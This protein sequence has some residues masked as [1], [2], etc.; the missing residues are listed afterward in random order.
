M[1]SI[2]IIEDEPAV[3]KEISY[4]I[5]QEEGAEIV[6]WSDSVK[7]ALI[8]IKEKQ[9]DVILMDIQLRDGTAFDI[10]K[11]LTPIPE[12]IIF[13]TAYNQFAIRAIKYGA[14]DY[15][16]K[17]IDQGELKEALER[18]RRR[19]SNNSQW[20]QQLSL[21]QEALKEEVILP[22]S[23]ALHSL[24]HVRIINVQDIVYCKGD[25]PYTFFLPEQW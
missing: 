7:T 16:L 10:L 13:I 5:Q 22:E 12:N 4:L 6:G 11:Q 17:P 8:L 21:A 14:L 19:S 24:N 1:T 23:I 9:P 3:R 18:Y 2:A 15:L 25:G 20:M